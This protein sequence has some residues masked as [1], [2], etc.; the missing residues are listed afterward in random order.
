MMKAIMHF[1][2]SQVPD[3]R[4]YKVKGTGQLGRDIAVMAGYRFFEV[5]IVGACGGRSGRAIT[6]TVAG[7]NGSTYDSG[8]GGG[9]GLHL[10]GKLV[11]LPDA[12]TPIV[13]GYWGASGGDGAADGP[14]GDGKPGE[15]SSFGAHS[16]AGGQGGI[17][18]DYNSIIRD[19]PSAANDIVYV[20]TRARGGAGGLNSAGLGGGGVGGGAAEYE[21]Q[22]DGTNVNTPRVAPTAGTWVAGGVY[23]VVGGGRGGG[24]GTGRVKA[25]GGTINNPDN[26]AAGHQGSEFATAGAPAGGLE[27]GCGGGVNIAPLTGSPT[28]EIHGSGWT[29]SGVGHGAVVIKLT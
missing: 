19:S 2:K 3:L 14:A 18:G 29:G 25:T 6:D 13:V 9:G 12:Q 15:Q 28:P 16:A 24:G 17:G 21:I 10:K 23:P 4:Q 1:D 26:G 8:P 11:D 27:G 7:R 20:T 5:I 22:G